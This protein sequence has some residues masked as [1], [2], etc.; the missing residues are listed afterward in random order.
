MPCGWCRAVWKRV[1]ARPRPRHCSTCPA[2]G[3]A[4]CGK[5]RVRVRVRARARVRVAALHARRLVP[6][7][8]K[9]KSPEFGTFA[10]QR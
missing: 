1:R 6:R 4:L 9:E 10:L 7:R 8:V 3:A 5:V 2:A